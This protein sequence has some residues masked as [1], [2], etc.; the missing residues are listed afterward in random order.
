MWLSQDGTLYSRNIRYD[1]DAR[2]INTGVDDVVQFRD[3]DLNGMTFK[4]FRVYGRFMALSASDR[5]MVYDT[6][7]R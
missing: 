3:S 6:Q 5:L 4:Q 1:Y 7:S 2:T